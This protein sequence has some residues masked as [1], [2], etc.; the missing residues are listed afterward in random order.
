[1]GDQSWNDRVVWS[2][3]ALIDVRVIFRSQLEIRSPVLQGK[4]AALGNDAGSKPFIVGVDET[5]PVPVLIGHCKIDGIAVT[6]GWTGAQ[7]SFGMV[8]SLVF[9]EQ[10]R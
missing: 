5:H 9:V 7:L 6:L 3:P 10:L 1:M 4:S 8:S 2:F